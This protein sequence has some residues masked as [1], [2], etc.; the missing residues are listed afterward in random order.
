MQR[1]E[2]RSIIFHHPLPIIKEGK[3]GSQVRP[4]QMLGAFREL[5]YEVVEVTGYA[6]ERRKRIGLVVSEIVAGRRFDFCYAES[7]TMPTL[8]TEPHH[9]PLFPFL[10]F[11]FFA[12]LKA[13][14][15]SVGLFYRDLHWRFEQ[16][17]GSV[18]LL[19]RMFAVPFYRH[20]LRQYGKWVDRLF[21]P[22]LAMKNALPDAGRFAE[23][24]PLPPGCRPS[25]DSDSLT[26]ESGD[27]LSLF[28]VGGVLPPLYDLRSMIRLV[29]E[30]KAVRL[31]LCCRKEEWEAVKEY[32]GDD[33]RENVSVVHSQGKALEEHY[34]RAD[35]FL[36]YWGPNA[37]LDFAFPVKLTESLGLGVP[38]VVREGTE[39]ARF[40]QEEGTGWVV[41]DDRELR[42]LLGRLRHD[43]EI[44]TLTRVRVR[45]VRERHTWKE[46]A[47]Q[48]KE[49][50]VGIR[51]S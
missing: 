42:D 25:E 26:R 21:L 13:A 39:A 47:R 44:L 35:V 30:I 8:L 41:R 23:V 32:Y 1:R 11:R 24:T 18:S 43:R 20:E 5:D 40:V 10:D 19:K 28:Y 51:R 12:R 34:A 14:R 17:R 33:I 16:Y 22:T 27:M 37:Y 29:G 38:V 2:P 46:R 6:R 4:Y 7:S 31:V 9:L 49:S 48:V 36:L 50:L 3:S 15:I 45:E